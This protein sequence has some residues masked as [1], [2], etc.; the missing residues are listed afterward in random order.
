MD[1]F[2][3]TPSF[4]DESFSNAGNFPRRAS[5]PV[6][7]TMDSSSY[8]AMYIAPTLSTRK[9][10]QTPAG[11]SPSRIDLSLTQMEEIK[12]LDVKK[13]AWLMKGG[14]K[15]HTVEGAVWSSD[16]ETESLDK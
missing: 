1:A 12:K 10:R 11:L 6:F 4:V 13:G 16:Y 5:N 8:A 15:H 7:Y 3:L 9:L 14:M 2:L